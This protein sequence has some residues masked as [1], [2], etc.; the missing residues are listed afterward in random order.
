M[1]LRDCAVRF[2]WLVL[3]LLP[4][5]P[6]CVG[7][8]FFDGKATC[9]HKGLRL[10]IGDTWINKDCY[11]CICLNPFGVGCCDNV[12]QPVDYPEWCKVIQRPN[13]CHLA[14]VMK[15]NRRIPCIGR[16]SMGRLQ[17][18]NGPEDNDPFF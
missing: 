18:Q 15:A 3:L 2:L 9:E 17:L 10:E 11:Q 16:T 5:A 7:E 6:R 14:V 13:S 4:Q 12:Q 8:C 1:V